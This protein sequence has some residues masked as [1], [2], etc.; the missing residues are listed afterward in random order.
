MKKN[1][2]LMAMAAG[3]ALSA[4]AQAVL[5]YSVSKTAGTYT[6]LTDAT[7]IYDASTQETPIG[8]A[9][10]QSV[11]APSGVQTAEGYVAGYDL[12]FTANVGGIEYKNFVVSGAGY[13]YL[14]TGDISIK[15][16]MKGNYMSA[17]GLYDIVGAAI[18]RDTKGNAATKISY[19]VADDALTV[20]YENIGMMYGF[21]GDPAVADMQ[22]TLHANGN[23]EVVYNNLANVP[24]GS[25]VFVYMGV[26]QGRSYVCTKA[27]GDNVVLTRNDNNT[28]PLPNTTAN[29][30]TFAFKAPA[31][32]VVPTAQPSDLQ[33][34]ATSTSVS[35]SFAPAADADTY[36]VVYKSDDS[37]VAFT[38]ADGTAYTVGQSVEGVTVAY[39]GPNT[40]FEVANLAGDV[41][42]PFTVYACNS[43]GLNGPVYNTVSPLAGSATTAPSGVA[44]VAVSK[45]DLSSITLNVTAN[46]AD[47][48][49]VVVYNTYCDRD[50]YGDHGLFG[51]MTAATAQGDVLPVPEGYQ[52]NLQ[53]P[54]T[55]VPANAGTVAYIGKGGEITISGLDPSTLYY[56]GVYSRNAAGAYSSDVVYAGGSTNFAA[57]ADGN[58]ANY[59]RYMLPYGWSSSEMDASTFNF[60]DQT[61]VTRGAISQ[62]TQAIQQNGKLNRGDAVNGKEAWLTVAPVEVN[63]AHMLVNFSYC[64]T[65]GASRFSTTAYNDWAEND[66]LAIRVSTDN[67]ATWTPVSTY[68]ATNHPS[69]DATLSYVDIN[70]DLNDYVDQQVLV[71]L[72]IKT[73]AAPAFGFNVYVDRFS[74]SQAEANAAP[75]VTVNDVKASSA[76]VNWTGAQTNYVVAYNAAGST[77]VT[78]VNVEGTTY[79]LSDLEANT[80]YEVRVRGQ[81]V[82]ANGYTDWS[83]TV[84]FTTTDWPAVDAPENLAADVNGDEGTVILTWDPAVDA[85]SYEV[86][87]RL[88]STTT[89]STMSVTEPTAVL[90][91]L[92]KSAAYVWKVRAYC[93]HGRVT[94]YSGQNRFTS[95]ATTGINA[96]SADSDAEYIDLAGRKVQNP[97]Q[98]IYLKRSGSKVAKVAIK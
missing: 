93:T 94:A 17:D 60:V 72:Y 5:G 57:P 8:D 47:N 6:P 59:P 96:V 74:I 35:G 98:G 23:F 97:A 50:N 31:N 38:P 75:V 48:D 65:A 84:S 70:A 28:L 43:Y 53:Y 66:M 32:C 67:G 55:P 14:G 37:A 13:I 52:S 68:T 39:Y 10:V 89:W 25:N 3:C 81:L 2:L 56:F 26:R 42:Y 92:E 58:S 83:E 1:L 62:G 20:Q 19:K 76:V 36:L 15:P 29:G 21:F 77:D 85:E 4:N 64:L 87:Y 90:A 9:M 82:N 18:Q 73:Y 63:V 44:A 30:T 11:F 12:G 22:L 34:S 88:A 78:E 71:Q 45:S 49:V 24:E 51:A 91:N 95:P 33:L 69:Q 86:A 16:S 61:Y 7:V 27:D 41:T 79:T 54:G 46:A 80:A 40:S